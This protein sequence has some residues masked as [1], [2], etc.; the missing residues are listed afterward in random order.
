MRHG[1]RACPDPLT[2]PCSL[3]TLSSLLSCQYD[4]DY[5]EEDDDEDYEDDEGPR[6]RRKAKAKNPSAP[7]PAKGAPRNYVVCKECPSCHLK[8][9]NNTRICRQCGH[10]FT[11]VKEHHPRHSM[12]GH[13][14]MI[15][16]TTNPDGTPIEARKSGRKR[17]KY[18]P[19][20]SFDYLDKDEAAHLQ[21]ALQNSRQN[22]SD[23]RGRGRSGRSGDDR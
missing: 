10:V 5:N 21:I 8:V 12:R 7:K 1:T 13:L 4:D 3:R 20:N 23:Q 2:L 18:N 17:T 14:D 9:G 15:G 16:V 22:T 11:N 6:K 19:A